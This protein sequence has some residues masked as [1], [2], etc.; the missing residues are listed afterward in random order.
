MSAVV[1][2]S[3]RKVYAFVEAHCHSSSYQSANSFFII[4]DRIFYILNFAAVEQIPKSVF[5]VLLLNRGEFFRY[6]A[7][8]R[9]GDVRSV[10]DVFH[11]AVLLSELLDLQAAKTF[12]RSA[13]HSVKNVVFFLKF[14]DFLIDISHYFQSKL[15]VF[16]N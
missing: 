9:I 10:A 8:E 6:V 1:A 12:C 7:V 4:V 15:T 11:Y 2:I 3:K 14:V 5:K 13:V 16:S